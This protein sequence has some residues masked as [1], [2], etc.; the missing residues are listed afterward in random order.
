[1]VCVFLF[2]KGFFDI[3]TSHDCFLGYF[4]LRDLVL[5][6][7]AFNNNIDVCFGM[8]VFFATQ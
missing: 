6:L 5:N 8:F 1:M 2:F 4:F 7:I 3:H